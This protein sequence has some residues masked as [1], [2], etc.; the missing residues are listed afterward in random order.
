MRISN[1]KNFLR[2]YTSMKETRLLRLQRKVWTPWC[3]LQS[4]DSP[5]VAYTETHGVHKNFIPTKTHRCR[6]L[7]RV[8]THWCRKHRRVQTRRYSL[9]RWVISPTFKAC[10]C[11]SRNNSSKS[12]V[13]VCQV[14]VTGKRF[15]FSK[16]FYLDSFWL[17]LRCNLQWGVNFKC[18]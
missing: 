14:L 16:F 1:I 8:W 18:E 13:S 11:S 17:T 15:L 5:G 4:P 6:L 2:C 10:Q 9:H 3:R 12:R 7:R